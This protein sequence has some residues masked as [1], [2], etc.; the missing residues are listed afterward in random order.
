M[1]EKTEPDEFH[2]ELGHCLLIV[3]E[4]TPSLKADCVLSPI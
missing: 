4:S 2:V 1:N 3:K